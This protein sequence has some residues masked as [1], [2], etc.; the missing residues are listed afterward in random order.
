MPWGRGY[1]FGRGWWAG[2]PGNPSWS[3]RFFPWLPRW[4]WA[5]PGYAGYGYSGAPTGYPWAATLPV[6]EVEALKQEAAF[7]REQLQAVEKRL[8][9]LEEK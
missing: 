6:S 4:W 3:C 8:K 5:T 1:G 9:E 7:L 2:W